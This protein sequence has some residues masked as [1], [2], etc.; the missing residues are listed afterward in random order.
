MIK[1]GNLF[2]ILVIRGF[3]SLSTIVNVIAM[4][5]HIYRIVRFAT[6]GEGGHDS[7]MD[8]ILSTLDCP[9]RLSQPKDPIHSIGTQ[10][11]NC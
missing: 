3:E 4:P 2:C 9:C 8:T 7:A 11:I 5:E 1:A 10:Q 6:S